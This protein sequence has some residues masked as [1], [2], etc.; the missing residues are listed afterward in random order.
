MHRPFSPPL[1]RRR[2]VLA[3]AGLVA[4]GAIS[5]RAEAPEHAK[6][7][8]QAEAMRALALARGDQG[9]GAVVVKN[10][11]I[12][13][14]GPSEVITSNDPTAHAEMQAI[15]AAARRLGTR[16]LSG[17][18]LYATFT[19]CPMCATAAHWARISAVFVGAA[20][21][22]TGAPRYGGC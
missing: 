12:V 22:P 18:A 2:L 15:R 3:G 9:F 17:C 6:F 8:R 14:E 11:A 13:G 1:P 4:A 21:S 5:A 16:D 19:P 7:M 20:A 10:G